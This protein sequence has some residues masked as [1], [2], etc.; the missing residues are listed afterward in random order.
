M[1]I[2]TYMLGKV[3]DRAQVSPTVQK[4]LG[5]LEEVDTE[6]TT[7]DGNGFAQ[8]SGLSLDGVCMYRVLMSM[9]NIN[10]AATHG[11][12]CFVN[13]DTTA[14]NYYSQYCTANGA[15]ISSARQ[16]QCKILGSAKSTE[17]TT[18]TVI[19]PRSVDGYPTIMSQRCNKISATNVNC[20]PQAWIY[21]TAGDI[22]TIDFT[23]TAAGDMGAGSTYTLYKRV[24]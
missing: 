15:A 22:T 7:A 13:S 11:V 1:P 14:T 20:A 17:G 8:I 10:A 19:Y 3:T 9:K 18:D 24:S 23:F 4:Q 2:R 21:P 5:G 6:T 12:Q 16:N